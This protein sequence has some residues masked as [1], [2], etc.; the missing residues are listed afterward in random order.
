MGIERAA[1]LYLRNSTTVDTG[2]AVDIRLLDDVN[3]GVLNTMQTASAVHTQDNQEF[4]FDPQTV[5]TANGNNAGTTLQLLGWALRLAEDM[6][7]T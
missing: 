5:P 1:V 6:T 4:T 7:P 2:G 3:A